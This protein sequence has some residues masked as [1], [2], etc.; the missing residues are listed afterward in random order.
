MSFKVANAQ[1]NS[2]SNDEL[3]LYYSFNCGQTWLATSYS[4]AGAALSTV[5]ILTSAYTPNYPLE[6]R[7]E[8][9]T[10]N[11]VKLKPNVRFKFQNISD[12]GNNTYIDDINVTGIYNSV[13]DID[14]LQTDFSLFPNPTSGVSTVNFSLS[15]S[16]H[17]LLEVKDI[18]GRIVLIVLDKKLDAGIHEFKLPVLTPGIYLVDLVINNKHYVRKLVVS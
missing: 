4:K 10:V 2:N 7:Q 17:A 5:G 6:W 14:E 3:R 16:N 11:S 1:R 8:I 18:L 13:G 12:R 9:V 15:K